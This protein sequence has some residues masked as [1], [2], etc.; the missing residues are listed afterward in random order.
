MEL[1][2][3]VEKFKKKNRGDCC[4]PQASLYY[5][6]KRLDK[7]SQQVSGKNTYQMVEN[8]AQTQTK[9]EGDPNIH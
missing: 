7:I 1:S 6:T 8:S 5:I 4:Y 3:R 2:E 9:V